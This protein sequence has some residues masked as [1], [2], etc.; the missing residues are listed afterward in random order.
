VVI[1]C[2]PKIL[3]NPDIVEVLGNVWFEDV[4]AKQSNDQKKNID[5]NST[6]AKNF[7]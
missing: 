5:A 6:H 1:S 3:N 7:I 4:Y 2:L